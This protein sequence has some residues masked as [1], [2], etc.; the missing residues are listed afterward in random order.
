MAV[1]AIYTEN[2]FRSFYYGLLLQIWKTSYYS[3]L[4]TQNSVKGLFCSDLHLCVGK[5]AI[6]TN[7]FSLKKIF[8]IFCMNLF[9]L[10]IL[11]SILNFIFFSFHPVELWHGTKLTKVSLLKLRSFLMLNSV[12]RRVKRFVG[13][14]LLSWVELYYTYGKFVLNEIHYYHIVLLLYSN[15]VN[16][17][18]RNWSALYI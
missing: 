8:N 6:L 2:T 10:C 3:H 17:Q 9:C 5:K 4:S 16:H 11:I 12:C 15:K 14:F 1:I 13:I 7:V 18:L